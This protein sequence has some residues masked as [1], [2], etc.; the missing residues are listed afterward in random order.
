MDAARKLCLSALVTLTIWCCVT[1]LDSSTESP[2][3]ILTCGRNQYLDI[4]TKSCQP[5]KTCGYVDHDVHSYQECDYCTPSSN[6]SRLAYC[7]E[8]CTAELGGLDAWVRVVLSALIMMVVP[9]IVIPLA[10]VTIVIFIR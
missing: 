6:V 7:P 5:C 9:V 8:R 4:S 1:G 10:L 2:E 3:G